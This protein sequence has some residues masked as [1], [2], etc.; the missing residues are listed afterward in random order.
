MKHYLLGQNAA[1]FLKRQM[2]DQT[3]EQ[4]PV[5]RNAGRISGEVM[6]FEITG[7]WAKASGEDAYSCKAKQVY[8]NGK[9]YVKDDATDAFEFTLYSP[10]D[11]DETPGHAVGN[12]VFAVIRGNH[13]EILG[14]GGGGGEGT[15]FPVL[16]EWSSGLPGTSTAMCSYKYYVQKESTLAWWTPQGWGEK[17]A[18]IEVDPLEGLY[19]R[20]KVGRYERADGGLA[21]V[22]TKTITENGEEKTV[23]FLSL[24]T[25]NEVR[26][27]EACV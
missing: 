19:R 1:D 9:S 13:W 26:T 23:P 18:R 6:P 12:T 20:I 7:D 8:W 22:K 21:H 17:S 25:I 11:R 16:L 10:Q 2:A 14:G 4:P 15:V 3:T 5:G 24:D 27:V